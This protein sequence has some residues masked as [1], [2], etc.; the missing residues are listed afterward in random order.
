MTTTA[1]VIIGISVLLI[2]LILLFAR[3]GAKRANLL[4]LSSEARDR[5]VTDWGRIEMRFVDEPEQAVR[6]ADALVMSVLRERGHTLR[7]RELPAEVRSARR[8]ASVDHGD[9]TERLRRALLQ[10]RAA[11]EKAVGSPLRSESEPESR[12]EMA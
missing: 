9:R 2:I 5:F 6:E 12:R 4:P 3:G 8:E 10:Y 11:M 1:L 7:E